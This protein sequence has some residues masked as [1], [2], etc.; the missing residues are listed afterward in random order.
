MLSRL[1]IIFL[2]RNKCLLISWLQ[3]PSAV[4]LEPPQKKSD[5]V[6]TVSPSISH[7][8]MCIHTHIYV[9]IHTYIHTN[10]YTHTHTRIHTWRYIYT[11]IGIWWSLCTVKFHVTMRLISGLLFA[12]LVISTLRDKKSPPVS[13]YPCLCYSFVLKLMKMDREPNSLAAH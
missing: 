5:T 10:M 6:S 12:D 1:V 8:V 3:S 7:E 11:H 9:S 4:I 2:P 13:S